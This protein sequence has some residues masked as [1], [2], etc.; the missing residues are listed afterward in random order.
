MWMLE[1]ANF[2]KPTISPPLS[3]LFGRY[4]VQTAPLLIASRATPVTVFSELFSFNFLANGS[5]C[6]VKASAMQRL[7]SGYLIQ[8]VAFSML[9]SLPILKI[10][11]LKVVSRWCTSATERRT[12]Y[13]CFRPV[14]S[15]TAS[16]AHAK[17]SSAGLNVD[18][19]YRDG[20]SRS[21][22]ASSF[23]SWADPNQGFSRFEIVLNYVPTAI[24]LYMYT[25]NSIALTSFTFLDCATVYVDQRERRFVRQY[26]SIDCE[27]ASYL[28]WRAV[29]LFVIVLELIIIPIAI[30]LCLLRVRNKRKELFKSSLNLR[31]ESVARTWHRDTY[32]RAFAI[33][34]V[35]FASR[36][37]YWEILTIIRRT[38]IVLLSILLT[39]NN[40]D[41]LAS[42]TFLCVVF[43][44][45]H[46]IVRPYRD[47]S[48]ESKPSEP[49][50][51]PKNDYSPSF[52]SSPSAQAT[53]SDVKLGEP[54][55]AETEM[56]RGS[57]STV[58]GMANRDSAPPTPRLGH[59]HKSGSTALQNFFN[60]NFLE[61]FSLF[62]LCVLGFILLLLSYP[63]NQPSRM[64]VGMFV[65]FPAILLLLCVI[66]G[67]HQPL[68]RFFKAVFQ[69]FKRLCWECRCP[70][71]QQDYPCCSRAPPVAQA[72]PP[73]ALPL[74][75]ASLQES[76]E[77]LDAEPRAQ[78]QLEF[79]GPSWKQAAIRN[80]DSS[81]A[82]TGFAVMVQ[83]TPPPIP[84][85]SLSGRA[86]SLQFKCL[87]GFHWR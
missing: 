42:T 43:L 60:E 64:F 68:V 31:R 35:P 30:G 67:N 81:S 57:L 11:Y 41:R 9:C 59:D 83:S 80:A 58:Y 23:S 71:C 39:S 7:L 66:M 16:S 53:Q 20:M 26:P 73:V 19:G 47:E 44:L 86:S 17:V 32:Y 37:F 87:R 25:F 33:L 22:T 51:T 85:F 82:T 34:F 79:G 50:A 24:A 14:F 3:R 74:R 28:R 61:S 56:T 13:A 72:V 52:S 12:C 46:T 29:V 2:V 1:N 27:S 65:L 48:V 78:R 70:L 6:L 5:S 15:R 76:R 40:L 49:G 4:F 55:G 69:C 45:L 77:Q 18:G 8:L 10:L 62:V 54:H 84:P 38:L 21:N 36:A 75:K 63:L